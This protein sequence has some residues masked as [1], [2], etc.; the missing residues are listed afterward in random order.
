VD[1]PEMSDFPGKTAA[2]IFPPARRPLA[3][4]LAPA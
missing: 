3:Q 2:E 1:A 4:G